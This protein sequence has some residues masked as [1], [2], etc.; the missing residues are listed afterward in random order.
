V[1]AD[2]D[3][4][5]LE[6]WRGASA[7]EM[8]GVYRR[9]QARFA[10][11]GWDT[12]ATWPLLEHARLIGTVGGVLLRDRGGALVGWAYFVDRGDE[13]QVGTLIAP[14]AAATA[15]LLDEVI[16]DAECG[17]PAHLRAFGL[18]D[19]PEL[20]RALAARGIATGRY[21]YLTASIAGVTADAHAG[22]AWQ[23]S[24][25]AAAASLLAAAYPAR[26][27]L[28]PFGQTSGPEGWINYVLGLTTT[29]GCGVFA[30]D[31]S[32]VARGSA[33]ALDGLAIVTRLGPDMAHLAQLAVAPAAQGRGL[34]PR[35]LTAAMAAA[36]AGGLRTMSLLVGDGN[37]VARRLYESRGFRPAASFLS[38]SGSIARAAQQA[39]GGAVAQPRR[40]TSAA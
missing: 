31:L 6:P 9:E 25:V 21:D 10:R 19:A 7:V 36:A 23:G 39:A 18:M 17:I 2:A 38:A 1:L 20:D 12:S 16:A 28:R 35:L 29:V 40:S 27:V 3:G 24:D 30:P 26:D 5:R 14:T 4:F 11:L 22:T 13:R 37:A 8:A 34:G 15:R 32:V 33:D